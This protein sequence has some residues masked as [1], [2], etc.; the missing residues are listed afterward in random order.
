MIRLPKKQATK[1]HPTLSERDTYI[2]GKA[3]KSRSRDQQSFPTQSRPYL[4]FF[5]E[6][7]IIC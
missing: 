3:M 1:L 7:S 5:P 6:K 4:S 2:Q